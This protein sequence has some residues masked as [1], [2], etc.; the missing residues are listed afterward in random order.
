MG[1]EDREVGDR[2]GPCLAGQQ[3]GGRRRGFEAH[4]QEDHLPIGVGAGQR[5][6]LLRGGEQL[7]RPTGGPHPQ[8][9]V[10]GHTSGHPQH[11]AVGGQDHLGPAGQGQGGIDGGGGRDAHRTAGPMEQLQAGRQQLV[12]APA[13]DRVGLAA[14]DLHHRPG[15][16]GDRRQLGRQRRHLLRHARPRHAHQGPGAKGASAAG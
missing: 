3:G 2:Q 9:I 16:G 14:A 13:H 1:A 8:Q 6:R 7:H 4:R 11:V 5:D 15:A 10:A 12:E